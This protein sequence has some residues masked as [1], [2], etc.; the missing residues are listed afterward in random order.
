MASYLLD[1]PFHSSVI[2]GLDNAHL[3]YTIPIYFLPKRAEMLK[4]R[5]QISQLLENDN[6]FPDSTWLNCFNSSI[7][8][9]LFSAINAF[10]V[11]FLNLS[12]PFR[13]LGR[14]PLFVPYV[15]STIPPLAQNS[16]SLERTIN[17]LF[18]QDLKLRKVNFFSE[19]PTTFKSLN[20]K[21]ND[22][23]CLCLGCEYTK[24]IP[25]CCFHYSSFSS[26]YNY[27]LL[28]VSC[29]SLNKMEIFS[30]CFMQCY[31]F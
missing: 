25:H 10:R 7:P 28:V 26:I 17:V 11:H 20:V 22:H 6:W 16:I 29:C 18:E 27:L 12:P 8:F 23:T 15:I 19:L 30:W 4:C 31:N 9:F 24:S 21:G 5:H 2:W 13:F 14:I 3:W 1:I